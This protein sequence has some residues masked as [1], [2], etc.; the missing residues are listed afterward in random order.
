LTTFGNI[1]DDFESAYR[2]YS[3]KY[4]NNK[5]KMQEILEDVEN[6]KGFSPGIKPGTRQ[7]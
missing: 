6:Y 1:Y 3:K 5:N 7:I 2:Q 4:G